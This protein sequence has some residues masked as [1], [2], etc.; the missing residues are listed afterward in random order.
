M[1][2]FTLT[3]DIKYIYIALFSDRTCL[4]KIQKTSNVMGVTKR[5]KRKTERNQMFK[6]TE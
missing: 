1:N 4:K 5:R 6:W 2:K 3:V